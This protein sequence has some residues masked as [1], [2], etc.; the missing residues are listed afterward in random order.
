MSFLT[1]YNKEGEGA[2]RVEIE[3]TG[4]RKKEI[5]NAS[6]AVSSKYMYW[7]TITVIFAVIQYISPR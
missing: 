6:I 3:A 2:M 7:L 4:A 1:G 5:R